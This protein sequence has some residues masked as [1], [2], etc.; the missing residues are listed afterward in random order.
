MTPDGNVFRLLRSSPAAWKIVEARETIERSLRS[1]PRKV[2]PTATI[3][4]L[5]GISPS[6]LRK[7]VHLGLIPRFRPPSKYYRPGLTARSVRSFLRELAEPVEWGIQLVRKRTRPAEEK[8]RKALRELAGG[9]APAPAEF[10]ARAGVAVTT[11]HRLLADGFLPAWY[12]TPHPP[13]ICEW[14]EKN[15]RKMLTRKTA[16]NAR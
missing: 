1:R 3:A 6:L 5:F 10:A 2:W 13:R 16:K 12:P 9:E 8:C 11:V 14:V 15:R 4:K 7:W